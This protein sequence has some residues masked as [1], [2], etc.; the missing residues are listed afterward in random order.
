MLNNA[1]C[2][3]LL[4]VGLNKVRRTKTKALNTKHPQMYRSLHKNSIFIC[5]SF[6]NMLVFPLFADQCSTG[7]VKCPKKNVSLALL[8][9]SSQEHSL[10][11]IAPVCETSLA[12]CL[13]LQDDFRIHLAHQP[14]EVDLTMELL[15]LVHL[16]DQVFLQ[17]NCVHRILSP[18]LPLASVMGGVLISFFLWVAVCVT[19]HQAADI[20]NE[21]SKLT[22]FYQAV[23]A[24]TGSERQRSFIV[25][26]FLIGLC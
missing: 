17:G 8:V 7:I 5:F 15:A 10:S 20:E 9:C 13:Q 4:G 23:W 3:F 14:G 1:T 26:V 21:S 2:F 6:P 24:V 12:K 16:G 19:N 18:Q 11:F 25:V 22:C